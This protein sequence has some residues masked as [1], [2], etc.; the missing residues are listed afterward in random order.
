MTATTVAL[1]LLAAAGIAWFSYVGKQ[2]VAHRPLNDRLLRALLDALLY[3]GTAIPGSPPAQLAIWVQDDPRVLLLSKYLSEAGE[4]GIR[5]ELPRAPWAEPYYELFRREL[6]A[7]GIAYAEAAPAGDAPAML[8]VDFGRDLEL[9][10]SVVRLA[11]ERVF[12]VHLPTR[13]VAYFNDRLLPLEV[14]RLT[15]ISRPA[16]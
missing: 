7:R 4:V 2:P 10:L 5:A 6:E 13:C 1:A 12:D 8:A 15:G 9:A 16:A 14:P 11:F 3:R